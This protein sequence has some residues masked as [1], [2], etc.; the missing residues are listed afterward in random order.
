[1]LPDW[2]IPILSFIWIF[3]VIFL[4]MFLSWEVDENAGPVH[5][6]DQGS[7]GWGVGLEEKIALL[8]NV[9]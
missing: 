3:D 9:P 6:I 1:M 8:I 7:D 2:V 5:H 4:R